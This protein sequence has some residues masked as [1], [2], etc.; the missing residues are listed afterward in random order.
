VMLEDKNLLLN[1]FADCQVSLRAAIE[2]Q[3]H[4]RRWV[5]SEAA[6]AWE[7]R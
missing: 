7:F 4:F 3:T 5:L 2:V 1:G 6:N